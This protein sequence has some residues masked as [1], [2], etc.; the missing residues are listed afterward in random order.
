MADVFKVVV[1]TSK[2]R[3]SQLILRNIQH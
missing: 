3:G 2:F 1:G